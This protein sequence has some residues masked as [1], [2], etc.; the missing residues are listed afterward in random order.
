MHLRAEHQARAKN[1][2]G[3]RHRGSLPTVCLPW[4]STFE[5]SPLRAFLKGSSGQ[6][7][8]HVQQ[9]IRHRRRDLWASGRALG[10]GPESR[11]IFTVEAVQ[12]GPEV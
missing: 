12:P 11:S 6:D 8:T 3:P 10:A 2:D 4:T 5:H 7:D 9:P 1:V